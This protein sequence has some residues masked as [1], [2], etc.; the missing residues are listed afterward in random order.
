M[1]EGAV[2]RQ[3]PQGGEH[4]LWRRTRRAEFKPGGQSNVK[5]QRHLAYTGVQE[6]G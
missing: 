6:L 2:Q 4:K 3:A 1:E 5:R